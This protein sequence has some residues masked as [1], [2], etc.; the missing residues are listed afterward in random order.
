MASEDMEFAESVS[1]SCG[2]WLAKF[3]TPAA[4]CR[5]LHLANDVF[6]VLDLGLR[7]VFKLDF[8]RL[9]EDDGS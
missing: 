9:L 6:R 2:P 5:V 7:S 3:S 4:E 8:H 1:E